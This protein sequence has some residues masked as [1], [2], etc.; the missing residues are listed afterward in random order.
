MSQDLYELLGVSRTATTDQ[1][2]TAY[3]QRALLVHPDKNIAPGAA[4]EFY[5]LLVAHQTLSVPARRA[6]YDAAGTTGDYRELLDQYIEMSRD[7]KLTLDDIE[8]YK[9]RY[10]GSELEAEDVVEAYHKSRGDLAEMYTHIPFMGSDN[11]ARIADIVQS[12]VRLVRYTEKEIN[13]A[14]AAIQDL[15][16]AGRDTVESEEEEDD[17][18]GEEEEGEEGDYEPNSDEEQLQ[19][20]QME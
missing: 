16:D 10:I 18:S 9:A 8:N 17:Y 13:D 4:E 12:R 5:Q 1:I 11:V 20:D 15:E 14:A 19:R 2:H 6:E 3:R 7:K